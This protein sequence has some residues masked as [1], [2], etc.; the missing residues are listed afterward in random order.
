MLELRI[1]RVAAAFLAVWWSV[2][3]PNPSGAQ[4]VYVEDSPAALE[5][6]QRAARWRAQ[7]RLTEAVGA[8]MELAETF[9]GKL[10]PVDGGAGLGGV[11][12]AGARGSSGRYVDATAW[13][14]QTLAA[15][16]EL[17]AAYER[18][19][20]PVAARALSV[21]LSAGGTRAG[22]WFDAAALAAVGRRHWSTPSGLRA[23]LAWCGVMLE[24]G[25]AGAASAKLEALREHPA[26]SSAGEGQAAL[27]ERY[28]N[29]LDA[30]EL[31]L[32]RRAGW[33]AAR[34]SIGRSGPATD[35]SLDE[36][37]WMAWW[38]RLS[39]LARPAGVADDDERG[40]AFG[41]ARIDRGLAVNGPRP[42]N[43]VQAD[44]RSLR[45]G[46]NRLGVQAGGALT[47]DAVYVTDGRYVAC[48]DRSSGR[49]RWAVGWPGLWTAFAQRG[50]RLQDRRGVLVL[51]DSVV[52]VLGPSQSVRA[53]MGRSVPP[54]AASQGVWS[55]DRAT[56][57]TRWRVLPEDVGDGL[58]G[59]Q[60]V[61]VPVAATAD[62]V[63]VGLRRVQNSGFVDAFVVGLDAGT[64]AVLW[65]RHLASTADSGGAGTLP[66]SRPMV[67]AGGRLIVDDGLG[68]VA[69]VDPRSGGLHWLRVLTPE[70]AAGGLA[71][72]EPDA[73]VNEA[74][75]MDGEE[76]PR[77]M[78]RALVN[79][80]RRA[81]QGRT[82]PAV[83]PA[84]L[85]VAELSPTA[86][87][88]AALLLDPATGELRRRLSVDESPWVQRARWHVPEPGASS[89]RDGLA[90][91]L[92]QAGRLWLIDGQDL[93]VV[94]RD[95]R[96]VN[97]DGSAW[98][99]VVDGDSVAFASGGTLRR[100]PLRSGPT[101]RSARSMSWDMGS[102]LLGDG[103]ETFRVSAQGLSGMVSPSWGERRLRERVA[104]ARSGRPGDAEPGLALA[105]LGVSVSEPKLMLDGVSAALRALRP[106]AD[107]AD[108]GTDAG[109]ETGASADGE[110][111]SSSDVDALLAEFGGGAVRGTL[112][113]QAGTERRDPGDAAVSVVLELIERVDGAETLPARVRRMAFDRVAAAV[114]G[115]EELVAYHLAMG[116]L[117]REAGRPREA[118]E[119]FQAVLQDPLLAAQTPRLAAGRR[120]AGQEART[121]LASVIAAAGF[122][123]Y[124]P[125]DALAR[126]ELDRLRLEAPRDAERFE[127][128]ADRFPL[129]VAAAEA[130]TQAG[131]LRAAST[132]PRLAVRSYQRAYHAAR[133][134]EP[135]DRAA[136][137][138]A[139]LYLALD[140]P[141][142]TRGWLRRVRQ[143]FPSASPWIDRAPA[144]ASAWDERLATLPDPVR[145]L[146]AFD[147]SSSLFPWKVRGK[148]L[149]VYAQAEPTL[150]RDL[151]VLRNLGELLVVDPAQ[152][153]TVLQVALPARD[154]DI[155]RF[156]DDQLVLVS[157]QRSAFIVFDV[158]RP[159]EVP[160]TI[161]VE[162][163]LAEVPMPAVEAPLQDFDARLDAERMD[164]ERLRQVRQAQQ[165]EQ[166]RAQQALALLAQRGGGAR[167]YDVNESLLIAADTAGRVVAFD[168]F[169]G[170]LQWSFAQPRTALT[171]L[172]VNDEAIV[173]VGLSAPNTNAQQGLT[174]VLDPLTGRPQ[175]PP[176]FEDSGAPLDARPMPDGS[177]LV[178]YPTF[179]ASH[180]PPE[181]RVIWRT[182]RPFE[183]DGGFLPPPVQGSPGDGVLAL[184]LPQ[185][186]P[187]LMLLDPITG[188][189]N[190]FVPLHPQL[191]RARRGA[192]LH[193][194]DG[195]LHVL[196]DVPEAYDADGRRLW[197]AAPDDAALTPLHQ[198]LARDQLVVLSE[199]V[200]RATGPANPMNA[201]NTQ[202]PPT[203]VVHTYDRP[204][205]RLR[206]IQ[207][208]DP[209]RSAIG[210]GE[211]RLFDHAL[212]V[213]SG[214]DTVFFCDLP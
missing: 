1:G 151:A 154:A 212:A 89:A 193:A 123:P 214:L 163:A 41:D 139:D 74:A 96:S 196:R 149:P 28:A 203:Y 40:D 124:A 111:L 137:R 31:Q 114:T 20:E 113:T 23:N 33:R 202:S 30:A 102:R 44:R 171:G 27:A 118:I 131:D 134:A 156:S 49:P 190:G 176:I 43:L 126:T 7:G 140:R 61:G 192:D 13:V 153:R 9:P 194:A 120:P 66:V 208:I 86:E 162:P 73:L 104:A 148:P 108:R 177:L 129:A 72:D 42:G 10:M 39:E 59:A 157:S 95:E 63:A 84:G 52:S 81:V 19:A 8:L 68:V 210:V 125:F 65:T 16:P 79:P 26:F 143:E 91:L 181:H 22:E 152:R 92:V 132:N 38:D 106:R 199:R 88:D 100:F 83:L 150:R 2:A 168:R 3:S 25:R 71:D 55:L 78:R 32:E 189:R 34:A 67:A 57:A 138:L 122:G 200:V 133:S 159:D 183:L 187:T 204:T 112:G 185:A 179:V 98:P 97:E 207:P 166:Q 213:P 87:T 119:H 21:A 174:L 56:G 182:P 178:T 75:A 158:N 4:T 80:A 160:M 103:G 69:S 167:F 35:V 117:E 90:P 109:L 36:P 14:R 198:S 37:V 77:A 6:A 211:V 161:S 173:L 195:R 12:A 145:S 17:R 85:L 128:L 46:V 136:G 47:G 206:A 58:T 135:R 5:L 141:D 99:P 107:A 105:T 110:A 184:R 64:G 164:L 29:L 130:L 165:Q 186:R 116:P 18:E 82:G 94:W 205:G 48:V 70:P 51:P 147:A 144:A 146:P 188:K 11:G 15:D 175:G 115:P 53:R 197:R 121:Q 54:P 50:Q 169:S 76:L 191:A 170:D 209:G 127:S 93:S 180:A 155:R 142:M 101:D 60:F 62:V 24:R 172:V 201:P 45:T